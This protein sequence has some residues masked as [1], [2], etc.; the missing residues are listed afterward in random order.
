MHGLSLAV[1]LADLAGP[2]TIL[3]SHSCPGSPWSD[4]ADPGSGRDW[5]VGLGRGCPRG[6]SGWSWW[7]L[8]DFIGP[9]S[10][11]DPGPVDRACRAMA[12]ADLAGPR[13]ILACFWPVSGPDSPMVHCSKHDRPCSELAGSYL[14][15]L[16]LA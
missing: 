10:G 12:V 8:L 9:N 2:G 3:A 15:W 11:H 14:D 7:L 16:I 6:D 1:V 4:L 5:V 13:R